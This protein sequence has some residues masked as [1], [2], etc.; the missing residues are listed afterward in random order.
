MPVP[1]RLAGKAAFITGLARGQGRAHAVR[2]AQEGADIVGIDLCDQIS[3]VDCPMSSQADLEE[4]VKLVEGLDRR[5]VARGR[6]CR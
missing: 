5:I 1:G 6:R 4:T 3:S 2:L